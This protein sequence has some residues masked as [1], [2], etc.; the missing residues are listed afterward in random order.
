MGAKRYRLA[1]I[2]FVCWWE[3]ELD[4]IRTYDTHGILVVVLET[5]GWMP[6]STP[7]IENNLPYRIR[8][9]SD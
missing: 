2:C 1:I 4:P 5:D 8:L 6:L 9:T 7:K 3:G